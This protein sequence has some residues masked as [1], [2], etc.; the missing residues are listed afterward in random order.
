M[1]SYHLRDTSNELRVKEVF[2]YL[3]TTDAIVLRNRDLKEADKIIVLYTQKYGKIQAVAKGLRKVKSKLASSLE[4]FNLNEVMLYMKENRN[5][6][7]ITGCVLKKSL[8]NLRQDIIKMSSASLVVELTDKL[9]KENQPSSR[10]FRLLNKVL[11]MMQDEDAKNLTSFFIVHLFS[12][13]GYKL[14]LRSCV[15]CNSINFISPHNNSAGFVSARF[16]SHEGGILCPQCYS[17]DYNAVAISKDCIIL[18]NK[19]QVT[20]I[21]KLK[22]L[23]ISERTHKELRKILDFYLYSHLHRKLNSREFIEKLE[24]QCPVLTG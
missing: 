10:V 21:S 17:R 5:L 8:Y 7:T 4:M 18:L 11:S 24:Y 2:M 12:S 16:S 15:S 22:Y 23:S 9:T 1:N 6:A 14:H 3:Y 13:L 19:L 20:H